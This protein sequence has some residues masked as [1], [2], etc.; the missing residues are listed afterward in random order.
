M[1]FVTSLWQSRNLVSVLLLPLSLVFATL[2]FLRRSAYRLG[3]RKIHR[4]DVPLVVVGNITV[5]G[6]GK[7][8]LVVWLVRFLRDQGLRPGIV[9]RGYRGTA[10]HWPQQVRPDSDP[11]VVG[12][13][14]VL[15]AAQ[16]ACPVCVGPDRAE[17][18]RALCRHTDI[19]IAISDDGLQ[20]YAMDRDLEIA[21]IDGDRRFGNGFMLPAGP[22]RESRGRLDQ[23]DMVV[24]NGSGGDGEYSMK[25]DQPTVYRLKGE[26][27]GRSLAH[28]GRAAVHAV[29]GIGNPERFFSLLERHGVDIQR[30]AFPDHHAY[31]AEDL[32]FADSMPVLMTD[33]DAVK[34]RRLP[35][36]DCWVVRVEAQPDA[37]FVH[38]LKLVLKDL[39]DG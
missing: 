19:N 17:A 23:V 32:S 2:A 21:V 31:R 18:V 39:V 24:V 20:H 6:T 33:K 9:S 10:R 35:C 30:H 15:L 3:I 36:S 13:E 11:T 14:A 12:D 29:A 27:D 5:G 16:A 4:F 28:F 7:T 25:L 37:Q 34:C 26:A 22:L 8:P 38:E 1:A